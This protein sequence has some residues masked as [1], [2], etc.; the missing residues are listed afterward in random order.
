MGAFSRWRNWIERQDGSRVLTERR[1]LKT[2]GKGRK[3]FWA[4]IKKVSVRINKG[5]RIRKGTI[6]FT[7]YLALNER[8]NIW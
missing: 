2:Y 1:A 3:V 4:W 6:F 5:G 8:M 7:S